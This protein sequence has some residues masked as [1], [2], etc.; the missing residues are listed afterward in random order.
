M[1]KTFDITTIFHS[2]CTTC[3]KCGSI[4]RWC[5][6]RFEETE[7]DRF[8]SVIEKLKY[9]QDNDKSCI[10]EQKLKQLINE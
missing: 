4:I 8:S 5:S 3:S 10:R 6:Y 9:H 2:E 1:K 7:D